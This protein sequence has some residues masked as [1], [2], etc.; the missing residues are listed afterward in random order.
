VSSRF[1][2]ENKGFREVRATR[3]PS[4]DSCTTRLVHRLTHLPKHHSKQAEPQTA[5]CCH[6]VMIYGGGGRGELF[7]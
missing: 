7:V 3:D 6:C 4:A 2:Y 5:V 1:C